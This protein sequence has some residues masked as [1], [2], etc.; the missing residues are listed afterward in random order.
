MDQSWN[1]QVIQSVMG[2]P[3]F[4]NPCNQA[5]TY[6]RAEEGFIEVFLQEGS[7]SGGCIRASPIGK[8]LTL[9]KT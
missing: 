5:A 2:E 6:M 3:F 8:Q 7:Y 4:F 1:T 9:H